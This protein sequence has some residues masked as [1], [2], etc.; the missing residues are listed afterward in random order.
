MFRQQYICLLNLSYQELCLGIVDKKSRGEYLN[1]I[2][3]LTQR[4]AQGIILGCTEIGLLV[5]QNDTTSTLYDTT[6]I[7]ARAAVEESLKY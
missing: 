4:G 6:F 2:Q 7:H 1:I 3:K 5:D